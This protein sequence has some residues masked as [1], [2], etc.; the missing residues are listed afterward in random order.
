MTIT[1]MSQMIASISKT[2][3]PFI[4][5][6]TKSGHATTTAALCFHKQIES[7]L[8]HV[9]SSCTSDDPAGATFS[10][11]VKKPGES[12]WRMRIVHYDCKGLFFI[13]ELTA[14]RH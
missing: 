9:R 11:S 4:L 14:T 1:A 12:I 13:N 10:D 3:Q 2:G 5:F 8:S 6:T 7:M